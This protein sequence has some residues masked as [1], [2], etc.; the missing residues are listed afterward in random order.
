V[1]VLSVKD[2]ITTSARAAPA[3]TISVNAAAVPSKLRAMMCTGSL[4]FKC[5][6]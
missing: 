5:L 3:L 4:Q 1:K 6:V 2:E